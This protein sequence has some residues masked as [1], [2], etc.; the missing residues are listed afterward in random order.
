M[1]QA[2]EHAQQQQQAADAEAQHL[3]AGL[4]DLVKM[5]KVGFLYPMRLERLDGRSKQDIETF[6]FSV[7]EQV[8]LMNHLKI[9][10][11]EESLTTTV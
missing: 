5:N 7:E 8:K 10:Y 11:L 3:H 6:C 9:V 1:E 2:N 4:Q